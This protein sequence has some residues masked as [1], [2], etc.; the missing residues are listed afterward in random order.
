MKYVYKAMDLHPES[1]LC[2]LLLAWHSQVSRNIYVHIYT[3]SLWLGLVL[4]LLSEP[5][6][7]V[8]IFEIIVYLCD[9]ERMFSFYKFT[10]KII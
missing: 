8:N 6:L 2:Q 7:I 4:A 9:I 3:F 5:F 10:Y 1:A